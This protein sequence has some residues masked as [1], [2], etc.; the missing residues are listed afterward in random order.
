MPMEPR[1]THG[2][3]LI[4]PG[5][6][7]A[8]PTESHFP[9]AD[10]QDE[11]AF[12]Q[13]PADTETS[14]P[15]LD[16]T[17]AAELA[18]YRRQNG[19]LRDQIGTLSTQ[20]AQIPLLQQQMATLTALI[21]QQSAPNHAPAPTAIPDGASMDEPPS[22][23]E[24]VALQQQMAQNMAAAIEGRLSLAAAQITNDEYNQV[25]ATMPY[26]ASFQEPTRSQQI[27]AAVNVLRS[28]RPQRTAPATTSPPAPSRQPARVVQHIEHATPSAA[29]PGAANGMSD[30]Q[31]EAHRQFEE[32][33]RIKNPTARLAAMKRAMDMS[34][35]ANGQTRED[36]FQR[37]WQQI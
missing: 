11:V 16:P 32:A 4:D 20:A 2:L 26:L 7:S 37:P 17:A 27:I 23:A 12:D 22:R 9:E 21:A 33:K 35:A 1:D 6:G 30:A 36:Y 29:A 24:M 3:D 15:P 31:S 5:A 34:L 14:P 19:L 10:L 8:E 18:E 25:M 28:Q 13:V